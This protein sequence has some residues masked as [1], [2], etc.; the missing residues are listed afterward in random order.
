MKQF[1]MLDVQN[2]TAV[3]RDRVALA[4]VSLTVSP[5]ELVGILGPNGAGKST[6]LKAVVGLVTLESG[7]VAYGDSPACGQ[8]RK[9]AYVPQRAAI[10]WSFP[11][12]VER[13]VLTGRTVQRGW[14]RS[15]KQGDRAVARA[16]MER[17][18][19][20]QWRRRPVGELSGGQQQRV[21]LARAIAQDAEVFLLDE[22]LTGVDR[23]SEALLW[24]VVDELRQDG[25][26]LLVSSHEWGRS[27]ER[28]DRLVLLNRSLVAVGEPQVVLSPE[29]LARTYQTLEGECCLPQ[30][31]VA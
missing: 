9:I 20:W 11:I 21:F 15:L 25:R 16:A 7:R 10:D 5:G 30:A 23:E 4:D 26:I 22:P 12:C 29:N 17:L 6:L 18:G 24:G 27:L 14:W 19:I 1:F 13:A 28:Y 31:S 8:K 3:Y 2:L